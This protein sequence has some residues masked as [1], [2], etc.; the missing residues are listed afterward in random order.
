M[1]NF[2]ELHVKKNFM[3]SIYVLMKFCNKDHRKPTFGKRKKKC[4]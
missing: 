1:K 3:I 2:N 4:N